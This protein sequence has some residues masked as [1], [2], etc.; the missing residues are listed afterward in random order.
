MANNFKNRHERIKKELEINKLFRLLGLKWLIVILITVISGNDLL[1]LETIIVLIVVYDFYI[2][3]RKKKSIFKKIVD[4]H[5]ITISILNTILC[6]IFKNNEIKL[7]FLII[8]IIVEF[9][10]MLRELKLYNKVKNL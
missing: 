8:S 9:I 5:L 10:M 2:T 7:F 4:I 1:Y 3:I 6:I